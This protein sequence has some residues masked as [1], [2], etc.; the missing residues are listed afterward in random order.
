MP[1]ISRR[2][3]LASIAALPFIAAC[4]SAPAPTPAPAA[5]S[6]EAP[7]P[8]AAEPT[9]PAAAAA[10]AT[11]PAE[12][13]KPVDA[14]KPASGGAKVEVVFSNSTSAGDPTRVEAWDKLLADFE[15][16]NPTISV[17]K[18]YV[19]DSEYYDKMVAQAATGTLPDVVSNR[20]DKM[21]TWSAS[22]IL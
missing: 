3:V 15:K 5:K 1:R 10:A 7:R 2:S 13:T 20:S 22:K 6:A 21:D 12:T 16:S 14:A 18:Q 9:K 19:P 11:K 8:A 4:G 17:K